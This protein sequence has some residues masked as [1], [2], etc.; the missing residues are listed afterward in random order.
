MEPRRR[1]LLVALTARAIAAMATPTPAL[2]LNGAR[3]QTND[4]R[5]A[6]SRSGHVAADGLDYHH[7]IHRRGEPVLVLHDG[8]QPK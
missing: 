8:A 1:A 4:A 6:P 3:M 7:A 5:S 2:A